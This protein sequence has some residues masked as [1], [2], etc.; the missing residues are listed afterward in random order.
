MTMLGV[1]KLSW[2]DIVK[3]LP[4][5]NKGQLWAMHPG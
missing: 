5:E 1:L 2:L 3:D 4:G